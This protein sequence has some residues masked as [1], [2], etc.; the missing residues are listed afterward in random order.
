MNRSDEGS[1][2]IVFAGIMV[3]IAGILNIFW[4][5]A[6]INSSSFFTEHATYIVS[7]LVTWGWI[8]L[9]IGFLQ[10]FAAY[11]I[12]AGGEFGRWFGIVA[13]GLNAI[14]ALLS[15]KAYPFWGICLFGIDVL[16]IYGLASYGGRSATA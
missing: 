13:A 11:S 9:I 8:V 10:L 16:I 7:D 1:G 6:A 4:G 15:I 14:S 2:W 5:I 3:L 12:F